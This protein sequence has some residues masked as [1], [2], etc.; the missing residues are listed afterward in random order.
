MRVQ[1]Q[2]LVVVYTREYIRFDLE[3][4]SLPVTREKHATSIVVYSIGFLMGVH[5][6]NGFKLHIAVVLDRTKSSQPGRLGV[7][8][9]DGSK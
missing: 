2:V 5:Y 8:L 7:T 1:T 4:W 6:L 9:K 3:R